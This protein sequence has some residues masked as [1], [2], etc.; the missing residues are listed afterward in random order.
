M[1]IKINKI[2]VIERI[3]EANNIKSDAKL[4]SYLGIAPTTLSSWRS[5]GTLDM[6][7]IY[8]KCEHINL[9]WLLTGKGKMQKIV[10]ESP[11]APEN[12]TVEMSREVFDL[13]KLQQETL[14]SQQETIKLL[15]ETISRQTKKDAHL[16]EAASVADVG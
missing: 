4:A 7:V 6:D 8:A 13:I 11:T 14:N 3:K 1:S 16:E 12:D 9:D 15:S 2:A 10:T 5:R